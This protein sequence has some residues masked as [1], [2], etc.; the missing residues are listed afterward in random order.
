MQ[1]FVAIYAAGIASYLGPLY[2][3][4]S[5]SYYQPISQYTESFHYTTNQL[6]FKQLYY[7]S[8]GLW[9]SRCQMTYDEINVCLRT[10]NP[11]VSKL[12]YG[13]GTQSLL[14]AGSQDARGKTWAVYLT[15]QLLGNFYSVHIIHQCDRLS[16]AGGPWVNM[17]FN[18]AGN[19]RITKWKSNKYYIFWLCVCSLRYQACNAH[20]PYIAICGLSG[21]TIFFHIIW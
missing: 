7:V 14:W 15:A 1:Q 21:S 8:S 6:M 12:F 5:L 18:N 19:V 13:K 17:I 10:A 9:R 16:P 11:W 4:P 2:C 3:K 20:A